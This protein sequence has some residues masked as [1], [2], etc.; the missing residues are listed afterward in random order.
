MLRVTYTEDGP[1]IVLVVLERRTALAGTIRVD[2]RLQPV[3]GESLF[4]R[5]AR[6]PGQVVGMALGK[7][8]SNKARPLAVS[9]FC[10]VLAW[11]RARCTSTLPVEEDQENQGTDQG[12]TADHTDDNSGD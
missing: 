4:A 10:H 6:R 8:A 9:V 3:V 12:K 1:R 11:G 5:Q 7:D 2:V